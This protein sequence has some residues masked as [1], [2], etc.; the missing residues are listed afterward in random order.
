LVSKSQLYGNEGKR[1]VSLANMREDKNHFMLLEVAYKLKKS[2]PDWTFHLVGK[3]FEDYYSEAIF[4]KRKELELENHV[5]LYGSREDVSSILDQ[6]DIGILTSASEGLP[7]AL[8]EYGE[9]GMS[10]V[11]TDVGE[12]PSIIKNGENGFIV[13]VDQTAAFYSALLVLVNSSEL[14]STL[15]N[16]LNETI[17]KEYSAKSSVQKYLKWT[18]T[19]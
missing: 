10:V 7:L 4:K 18:K 15:G 1:I 14:R 8:L 5:F 17:K 6:S 9:H 2:H 19:L 13:S 12:I 11:V 16:A 3:D